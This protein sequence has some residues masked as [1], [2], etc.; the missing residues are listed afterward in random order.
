MR[1]GFI[2]TNILLYAANQD[3]RE[4]P[5]AR[6]FL[7]KALS[8]PGQWYLS[9]GICYEFLRVATHHRVFPTPLTSAHALEFLD[10]LLENPNFSLL[11]AG[12]RHWATLRTMLKSLHSPSGNLFFDIRTATL[13][14]E[15]GVRII[16]T[17]DS[18]FLQFS[19]LEVINP[20]K[21]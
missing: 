10:A 1:A 14:F 20:L 11:S 2:D 13:M 6:P 12:P 21:S 4:H 16:Y 5:A 3:C 19:E 17:A 9:E 8:Q 15:H 7:E 18:D